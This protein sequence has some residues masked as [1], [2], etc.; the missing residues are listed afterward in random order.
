[1]IGLTG[2]LGTFGK[3]IFQFN[4]GFKIGP[5]PIPAEHNS[6][7]FKVVSFIMLN[8]G[9]YKINFRILKKKS[10]FETRFK[11]LLQTSQQ[12]SRIFLAELF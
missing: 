1:M 7:S 3:E 8:T 9:F 4:I 12:H 5:Q 2:G 6:S 11:I 10:N